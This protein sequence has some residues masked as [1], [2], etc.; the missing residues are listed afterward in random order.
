MKSHHHAIMTSILSA[1]DN[2][3]QTAIEEAPDLAA[4]YQVIKTLYHDSNTDSKEGASK[5]LGQLQNSLFA[6]KVADDLLIARYDV[7]SCYFAAQTLRTKLQMNFHE[8]P[9]EAYSSLKDS[10]INH[11]KTI[12]ESVIQTQLSLAITY[13][14]ILGEFLA[15]IVLECRNF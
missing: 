9:A 1:V 11:L 4:V 13:L 15:K 2:G 8:L 7:E 6:W 10:I 12:N 3:G 14:A 5:W